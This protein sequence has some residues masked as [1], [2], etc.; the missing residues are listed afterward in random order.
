MASVIPAWLSPSD[1]KERITRPKE[2]RVRLLAEVDHFI[3]EFGENVVSFDAE[4]AK[5]WGE[6]VFASRLETKTL[7]ATRTRK[8]PPL[9]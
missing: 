6:Y 2:Q 8:L 5:V 9:L 1:T 7:A 4:A 3:R